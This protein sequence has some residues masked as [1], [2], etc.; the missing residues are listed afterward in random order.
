MTRRRYHEVK[1][2][3]GG[4]YIP[5]GGD[6]QGRIFFLDAVMRLVPQA[7]TDLKALVVDGDDAALD[8]WCA[9]WGFIA[10]ADSGADWLRATART[11]ELRLDGRC[12]MV[13]ED[14]AFDAAEGFTWNLIHEPFENFVARVKQ[15]R[16]ATV[17][18]LDLRRVPT[19]RVPEGI[20]ERRPFEWLALYQVAGWP[21]SKIAE[22]YDDG[23]ADDVLEPKAVQM[24]VRRLAKHLEIEL[25]HGL[26]GRPRKTKIRTR[27]RGRRT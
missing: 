10:T 19:I 21:Y 6:A 3:W 27:R 7:L 8:A 4:D 16:D 15:W 17:R 25:S 13:I 24:E 14:T 20:N 9:R 12:V 23:D 11:R 5:R 18:R 1:L 22:H 2:G 26:P